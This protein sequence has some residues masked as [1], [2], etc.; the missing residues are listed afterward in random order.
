MF[1]KMYC[2]FGSLVRH[3]PRIYN[4]FYYKK[5]RSTSFKDYCTRSTR[6]LRKLARYID[7]SKASLIISTFPICTGYV[8]RYKQSF[9][10]SLPLIT[11]ITDIVDGNEWLYEGNDIYC[12]PV[13]EIKERLISKGV[14]ESEVVVTGIPVRR[15]FVEGCG[16]ASVRERMGYGPHDLVILIM[17]GRHGLIP[18]DDAFYR[19]LDQRKNV[20]TTVVTG[21][22]K[23]VHDKLVNN[24]FESVR[25][26]T[27]TNEVAALMRS[28]DLLVTKP[29]GVTVFEA[30]A[31]KLPF[32]AYQPT[33]GQEIE[34]CKFIE[35]Q[36]IGVVA[37]DMGGLVESM[38]DM[39]RNEK[40]R[41]DFRQKLSGLTREMD[42]AGMATTMLSRYYDN[43]HAT[44]RNGA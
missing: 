6:A 10:N 24:T 28:A 39:M 7:I 37:H 33:L 3:A 44:T 35:R 31:S 5:N 34:N 26:V 20:Y 41:E 40:R 11:C 22:N 25:V 18:E 1:K 19:W 8:A 43:K 21:N 12:V 29:G 15:G 13:D 4:Y 36:R 14:H 32:I 9:M 17:G 38:D 27:H 23:S 2:G 42:M 30:I 16:R